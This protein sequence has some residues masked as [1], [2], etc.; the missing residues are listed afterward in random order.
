MQ[1]YTPEAKRAMFRRYRETQKRKSV[2]GYDEAEAESVAA[3]TT[4]KAAGQ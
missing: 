4:P 1:R 2:A 3:A